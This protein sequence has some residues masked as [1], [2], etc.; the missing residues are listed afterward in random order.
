MKWTCGNNNNCIRTR[1]G[2]YE[3][4]Y[5]C[6]NNCPIYYNDYLLSPVIYTGGYPFWQGP[7]GAPPPGPPP[8][9]RP[10]PVWSSPAVGSK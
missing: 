9:H 3:T 6:E 10:R 2:E 7:Y 5:D 4:K 1:F 8:I